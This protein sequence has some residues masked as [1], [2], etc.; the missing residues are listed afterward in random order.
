MTPSPPTKDNE[1]AVS[2]S[3][4]SVSS[5][6]QTP[7]KLLDGQPSKKSDHTPDTKTEPLKQADKDSLL[8]KRIV[9]HVE[10][11]VDHD[12]PN[13]CTSE[14]QPF[15]LVLAE[16]DDDIMEVGRYV[17]RQQENILEK[18]SKYLIHD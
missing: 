10:Y 15:E 5:G 18:W 12:V 13:T 17:T 8:S 9:G 1:N 2:V 14:T 6:L 11:P 7:K 4:V 3:E 16:D